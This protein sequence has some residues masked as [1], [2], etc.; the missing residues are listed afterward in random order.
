MKKEKIILGVLVVSACML[1]VSA[2]IGVYVEG[3]SFGTWQRIGLT[4]VMTV[5]CTTVYSNYKKKGL[6]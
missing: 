5:L 6:L 4:G 3:F 1:F 2:V